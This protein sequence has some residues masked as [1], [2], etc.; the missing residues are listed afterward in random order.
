MAVKGGEIAGILR[1]LGDETTAD[2]TSFETQG[3]H[4]VQFIDEVADVLVVL[5][6]EVPAIQH[7]NKTVDESVV[8]RRQAMI[9]KVLKTVEVPQMQYVDEILDESLL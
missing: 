9:Q 4:Q 2:L 6:R 7:V 8:L 5:Q 1:Q 3:V